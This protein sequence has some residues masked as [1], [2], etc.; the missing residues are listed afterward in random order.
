VEGDRDLNV[1][2]SMD[3]SVQK[4]VTQDGAQEERG[5]AGGIPVI[6]AKN[7]DSSPKQA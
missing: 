7:R 6:A 1:T 4:E 5:K 2:E 3:T